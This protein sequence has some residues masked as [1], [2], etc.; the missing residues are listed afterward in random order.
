MTDAVAP[1]EGLVAVG[2]TTAAPGVPLVSDAYRKYALGLLLVIYTL[3]F[4]DRQVLNILME[5]I[6]I[7]FGL[8]DWQLGALSGLA[9]AVFYTT[10]GIPIARAAETK[11]RGYIIAGAVFVWSGFTAL[12]AVATSFWTLLLFRIGVGVGEAGCT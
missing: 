6:K 12:C 7:E 5:D 11:H 8:R 3:N 4:L 2:T 10:L 1:A 9:F